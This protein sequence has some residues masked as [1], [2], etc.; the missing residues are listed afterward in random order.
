MSQPPLLH[1]LGLTLRASGRPLVERLDWQVM[2]G[3]RW[4]V[5]GRNAA[6]NQQR[7]TVTV[8]TYLAPTA[9][10]P[11]MS[12]ALALEPRSGANTRLWVVNPDTDTV[13]V[14]DA[15]GAVTIAGSAFAVC[16]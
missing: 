6:G 1:A 2:P 11:A 13:S 4:C 15:V 9:G 8:Q 12:S 10:A 3:Q 16:N 5:I 14:F 7:Q